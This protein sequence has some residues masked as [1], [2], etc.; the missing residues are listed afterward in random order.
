MSSSCPD[1]LPAISRV[2]CGEN[3]RCPFNGPVLDGPVNHRTA[4]PEAG[5]RAPDTEI[6]CPTDSGAVSSR[7]RCGN[8]TR[9]EQAVRELVLLV[10]R[11]AAKVASAWLLPALL[12]VLPLSSNADSPV[13][14]DS[15]GVLVPAL[16]DSI[17][18][19][20]RVVYVD[21]WASWCMPCRASFPWLETLQDTYR[22]QG[23][24][25]VTIDVDTDPAAGRKF[26]AAMKSSLPVVSDPKGELAARFRLEVMPSSFV[27]GR[28]GKLAFRHQG[29]YPRE[30][31][32]LEAKIAAL[33]QKKV[34]P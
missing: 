17:P 23:L 4:S 3:G 10:A 27:Y 28:D 16:G 29:F 12:L 25:V 32:T 7:L 20:G 8:A 34:A 1:E 2:W 6:A 5:E 26:L 15:I 11:R 9:L 22:S 21:F 13:S 18:I 31:E 19:E 33:L 24:Q 30:K 14:I